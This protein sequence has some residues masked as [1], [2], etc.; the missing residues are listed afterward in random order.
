MAK[1]KDNTFG[2]RV[3]WNVAA[4]SPYTDMLG[5]KLK[6]RFE[7]DVPELD[8]A[9]L[10][11]VNMMLNVLP[12]TE[13]IEFN[14]DGKEKRWLCQFKANWEAVES[15]TTAQLGDF[16]YRLPYNIRTAW[17][18]AVNDGQVPFEVDPAQLPTDALTDE[19]KVEAA[20]PGSPLTSPG[21][22]GP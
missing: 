3:I 18:T 19:Q 10:H 21:S 8:G 9:K 4:A 2:G 13:S 17:I 6:K 11:E 22:S 5:E 1:E 20:T 14:F 16:L 12:L 7:A 15:M